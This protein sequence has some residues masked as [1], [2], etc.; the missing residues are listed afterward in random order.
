MG[1]SPFD[2]FGG[3]MFSVVPVIVV[4]G[5]IFVI[6]FII[7]QIVQGARQWNRNNES[8]VLTVDAAVVT[9][10][11]IVSDHHHDTGNNS[12]HHSTYTTY[13]TTFQVE[14]GD[15]MEFKVKSDEYGMLAEN[16]MGKLTFQGTRYLGF[17]RTR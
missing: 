10:R 12:F 1:F 15:R 8:P 5:F 9:K 6:G 13:Y 2:G 14:S 16:D 3:L 4:I 7:V 17:K 11:T